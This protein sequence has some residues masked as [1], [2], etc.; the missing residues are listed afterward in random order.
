[1][2]IELHTGSSFSFLEGASLPEDLV[3]EAARLGYPALALCDRDGVYG[4]PRFHKAA[5]EAGIRPLV[6]CEISLD[7][8]GT[9]TPAGPTN[10]SSRDARKIKNHKLGKPVIR[11]TKQQGN[12]STAHDSRLTVLVE[13]RR[14]YQ[15]LCRLL[16][17][18]HLGAPK[19]EG[20]ASWG[21][22]ERYSAG[23]IAL[24]NNLR[25]ADRLR[26]IFGPKNLYV[27]IQR[28]F[29]REQERHNRTL[30]DYARY[31][32]LP[33]LA[34]N[35]VRYAKKSGRRLFDAL[36][37]IREKTVLDQVGRLLDANA[38]R[39]LKSP[40][41]M[42]G[43]F[44]DLPEAIRNTKDLA[45]RLEFTLENL[46]Y[47]FP[48]YPVPPGETMMSYLC[49]I[50]DQG[51]R[52][53]YRPYH[54][55]ACRQIEHELRVID[56]LNLAGYFLIVWDM[57]R[58]CRENRILAQ[59]RGSAANSAVCY[60]LGITAVDPVGMELLF[61]R[62][63]SEER[64]EWPDIDIDLPSG[65]QRE[66]A[67]QHVYEQYG[68]RGAGMTANVIT[69]RGKSAV[70]E[71]G[72]VLGFPEEMIG[73]LSNCIH[74]FEYTDDADKLANQVR[75][76]GFDTSHLRVKHLVKLCLEI[77]NLPRHLGQ[78]SG[79]MVIC[80][81]DLDSIVP[82]E[83]A[84]M[85]GRVV[86]QWDKDDCTDL[87]IIKVDLLGLGM[88]AALEESIQII[89]SRGGEVDLAHLPPDDPKTY[90]MIQKA[91]TVG[92][93]QIESR[94]QMATLPRLKPKCF[95]DLVVEVAII[96]PGPIVGNMVHPYINRRLGRKPVCYPHPSLEPILKR[97]LGVPLFQEQLL[98]LAMVA[99]DFT[100]GEA[101]E[102]RRAMGFKRSAER[103]QAIEEK[104]RQGLAANNI[105]GQAAEDIVRSITS[106]ALYGFPESHA[107]S[108]ALLA[109]ASCYLKT[110]YP[111]A[112][113][114]ALLNCQPMGF[115]SPAVLVKDAQRHGIRVR[116]I[117][118]QFSNVRCQVEDEAGDKVQG[119][120]DKKVGT[121]NPAGPLPSRDR[122]G[123]VQPVGVDISQEGTA[124]RALTATDDR[125]IRLGLMYVSGL[126]AGTA[127][128]IEQ[129]RRKHS[130]ASIDDLVGRVQLRKPELDTLAELGALNSLGKGLH[131]RKALWQIEKAW[132]PTGP[133]FEEREQGKRTRD[134]KVGTGNHAGRKGGLDSNL[135]MGTACRAPT[136]QAKKSAPLP[137]ATA[138][139][140]KQSLGNKFQGS[141]KDHSST[142]QQT[143]GSSAHE[144]ETCPLAPMNPLERLDADYRGSGMTTGPHPM[145]YLREPLHALGVLP[146]VQLEH[147]PNGRW[148]RVAGAVITRQRPGTAKGFLFLTL[149]DET[150]VS[151]VI[152]TP[153]KFQ[154]NRVIVTSEPFLLVEGAL[155]KQDGVIHV[156][157]RVIKPLKHVA[158][159][160]A[161]HDFH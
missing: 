95:Y 51:A 150:G 103:M 134:K 102:L 6:G 39:H 1:M 32:G 126:R 41:E 43:L 70:C 118:V 5:T 52:D 111:A 154:D 138:T 98:R 123:A 112:F 14:G 15:N 33:L 92:T 21:D 67:L 104:L 89:R 20:R 42:A 35:C 27:E 16:T 63:L 4:A 151:N 87:G 149:E 64:G 147:H 137:G 8:V 78:H 66:K 130:F 116:P 13:Y 77:Q 69:Y 9:G 56:K 59:G 23:L 55:R 131:R 44:R 156:R 139:K 76:A 26:S 127:E 82:L 19:G 140:K 101:E 18:M 24:T 86:V 10:L 75:T 132:R 159:E 65:D 141:R 100:G 133:L 109:Y 22:V 25:D 47:E 108:F 36:T 135:P 110:H 34:T 93:F 61:E 117:D 114:T 153:D 28:H 90:A 120:R 157:A 155:Q 71:I 122:K 107:A 128:A 91:D 12:A 99:A 37:C 7:S 62:F 58:F 46:G 125:T 97:T 45:A 152:V 113:Y 144:Q 57:V 50:T 40:A 115:Y 105:H 48:N 11:A 80:R 72:K 145:H 3:A 85:P 38:E 121:G 49:K 161:S 160:M 142:V 30:I 31:Y 81:G 148:V 143:N 96:R 17:R 83:N 124:C 60:S 74:S 119:T 54:E 53:R 79:G 158:L 136:Q 68:P 73:R 94:A 88:M 129:E 106:F 146:A 84:R 29:R 2:Y